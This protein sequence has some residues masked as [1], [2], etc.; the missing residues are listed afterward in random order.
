M[1]RPYTG[2]IGLIYILLQQVGVGR[3]AVARVRQRRLPPLILGQESN[4]SKMLL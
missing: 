2:Y 3:R 1:A 4:N